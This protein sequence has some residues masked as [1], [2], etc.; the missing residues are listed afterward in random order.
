M[1]LAITKHLPT[2]DTDS[3][4][5][6]DALT[7]ND[8]RMRE[9]DVTL[10]IPKSSYISQQPFPLPLTNAGPNVPIK[11]PN[12][13]YSTLLPVLFLRSWTGQQ[14]E[15]PIPGMHQLRNVKS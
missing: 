8:M 6:A 3:I 4:R 9:N 12:V 14:S 1:T 13:P 2:F 11:H 7:A 5:L 10:G 15:A